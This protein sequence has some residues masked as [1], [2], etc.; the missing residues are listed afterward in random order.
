[1]RFTFSTLRIPTNFNS[2][3]EPWPVKKTCFIPSEIWDQVVCWY[4]GYYDHAF[5]YQVV[6]EL[7]EMGHRVVLD[8]FDIPPDRA[9][10]YVFTEIL[11]VLMGRENWLAWVAE[12][13]AILRAERETTSATNTP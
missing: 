13:N 12:E 9:E 1:M 4:D 8:G 6:F 2:W 3:R 5:S 7:L 10:E 11:P